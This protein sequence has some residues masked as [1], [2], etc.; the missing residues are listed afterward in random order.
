MA[1]PGNISD[2]H[3]DD[4]DGLFNDQLQ[5]AP[6]ARRLAVGLTSGAVDVSNGLVIALDGKWGSGKSTVAA[7]CKTLIEKAAV[8]LENEDGSDG[9]GVEDRAKISKILSNLED[10]SQVEAHSLVLE[11]LK[12]LREC[13]DHVIVD[14]IQPW[15][16]DSPLGLKNMIRDKIQ[17]HVTERFHS[18]R[19]NDDIVADS[20]W[21]RLKKSLSTTGQNIESQFPRI[22]NAVDD[23]ANAAKNVDGLNVGFIGA[24]RS[25]NEE[26]D[27]ARKQEKLRSA[28]RNLYNEF[29]CSDLRA[30]RLVL[31]IDDIDRLLPQAIYD[32]VV[33]VRANLNMPGLVIVLLYD[34]ERVH[35]A[36]AEFFQHETEQPPHDAAAEFMQ[37][38]VEITYHLRK[39]MPEEFVRLFNGF[40]FNSE[41][42]KFR[43]PR[44]RD[45]GAVIP[46][47]F[48]EQITS[49]SHWENVEK[50][51]LQKTLDSP[52]DAKR[53]FNNVAF[54]WQMVRDD[55]CVEDFI[56]IHALR[57][58]LPK[59]YR[60]MVMSLRELV[61]AKEP[62]DAQYDTPVF[63]TLFRGWA[64]VSDLDEI[65]AFGHPDF[66]HLYI[67]NSLSADEWIHYSLDRLVDRTVTAEDVEKRLHDL[68]R[69]G[70]LRSRIMTITERLQSL[71]EGKREIVL[72]AWS[73]AIER[74]MNE[75]G[76]ISDAA[77]LLADRL[78]AC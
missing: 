75:N 17:G 46:P 51:I 28:I 34:E 35:R 9:M 76:P 20:Y 5:H 14:S 2:R 37:K 48:D 11:D 53:L 10:S 78:P 40:V 69:R 66:A 42:N 19:D 55:L 13:R 22:A 72:A 21:S 33:A 70:Q 4:L 16:D 58:F 54:N 36:L 24:S 67:D 63:R 3:L 61:E 57:L 15:L 12:T 32:L 50:H 44:G 56:A 8:L 43:L 26:R 39:P 65:K 25:I 41:L 23:L 1:V 64:G 68:E 52:R 45:T 18:I 77:E 27:Y 62:P 29:F 6:F 74:L 38:I 60:A 73:E 49:P 30:W 47:P 71:P 31:F 7:Y 59:E